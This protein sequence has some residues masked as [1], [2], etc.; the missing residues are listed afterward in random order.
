MHIELPN[1]HDPVMRKLGW[2]IALG[3]LLLEIAVLIFV[4][5]EIARVS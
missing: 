1:G 4:C 3:W 5:I 2:A